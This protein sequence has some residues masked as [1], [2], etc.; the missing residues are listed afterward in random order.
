MEESDFLKA[1]L[2]I[3]KTQEHTHTHNSNI[4]ADI[5]VKKAPTDD[6]VRLLNEMQEKAKS[7]IIATIEAKNN[8][9]DVLGVYFRANNP[10]DM[11]VEFL[12][13]FKLNGKEFDIVA[14][15]ERSEIINEAKK[16]FGGYGH[17]HIIE[18]V[19][20]K[21]SQEIAKV[22]LQHDSINWFQKF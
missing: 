18:I 16:E 19:Y 12:A 15:I 13:K 2:G 3:N 22:L 1:F 10:I 9:V 21:L 7:N 11:T 8:L 6:S 20:T 4:N 14:K 5:Y 17:K